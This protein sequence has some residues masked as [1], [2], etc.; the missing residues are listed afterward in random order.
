MTFASNV[1][2][3]TL[4]L[5]SKDV[6]SL[7]KRSWP[8]LTMTGLGLLSAIWSIN[9]RATVAVT[10]RTAGAFYLAI[11]IVSV[12]PRFQ[13]IRFAIRTMVLGC[14]LSVI[15]VFAFPEVAMHHETD[16]FQS[17]HAGLWRG[18]FSHK[19]GLGVFAGFTTALLLVYRTLIF[20]PVVL[21]GAIGCSV[22]CL[23]GSG[24]ATGFI[25]LVMGF[26]VF[27]LCRV[28]VRSPRVLRRGRLLSIC[29]GFLVLGI[30][31][32]D[33]LLDPLIHIIGKSSDL[34]GRGDI[35]P[36]AIANFNNSGRTWLGGGFGSGLALDI[37][38]QSIDNGYLDMIIDFGYLMAPLLFAIYGFVL[39]RSARLIL[40]SPPELEAATIFPFAIWLM[41]LID[42]ITESSFMSKSYTSILLAIAVG[43]LFDER[44]PSEVK[45]DATMRS[46]LKPWNRSSPV[47]AKETVRQFR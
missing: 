41:I 30:G 35:W 24:S 19:Q 16:L 28:V 13:G 43:L 3:G 6:R 8:V 45:S 17:V 26:T 44:K 25:T 14:F 36:I 11:S 9:P 4:L 34:T 42:N 47:A 29:G 31:F 15:W 2:V 32:K 38:E 5:S 10:F 7:A 22:S 18:I 46:S 12:M 39:W 33:G 20:P 23:V 21:V 1:F 27:Y 40:T 37:S